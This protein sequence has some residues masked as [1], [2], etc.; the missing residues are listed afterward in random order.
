MSADNKSDGGKTRVFITPTHVWTI[1]AGPPDGQSAWPSAAL[2]FLDAPA[3]EEIGVI[4]GKDPGM[5]PI[6]VALL[7]ADEMDEGLRKLVYVRART[8]SGHPGRLV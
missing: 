7:A 3:P 5:S 1:V 2:K 6:L 8:T 4:C